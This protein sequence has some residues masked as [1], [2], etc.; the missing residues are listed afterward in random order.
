MRV[1]RILLAILILL[2]ATACGDSADGA[3]AAAIPATAAGDDAGAAETGELIVFAAASLTDAFEELGRSFEAANAGARVTYNFAG[4]QQ[5]AQQV[6]LGAPADVFASASG[7]QMDVVVGS[8]QVKKDATQ[9]FVRNKLVVIHP[10]GNPAKLKDLKDLADSGVKLDLAAKEVP[11]G[12][13][14]LDLLD[15]AARDHRYGESYRHRVIGNV[16]SYEENVEA[17]VSK[18]SLGEADAGIVYASDVAADTGELGRI[19]IPERLN[20]IATY[21]IAPVNHSRHSTLARRFVSYVLSAAGQ[22][23]LEKYGFIPIRR[24]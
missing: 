20:Q 17:V 9:T 10:R 8:G 18:V 2:F 7:R 4:S 21:P 6:A 11:A 23:T 13:Y 16:V 12:Q 24:T 3:G 14:S 15:A 19:E 1:R 5:L 22:R